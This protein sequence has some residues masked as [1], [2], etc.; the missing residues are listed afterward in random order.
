MM[1]FVIRLMT[2]TT[3]RCADAAW[4]KAELIVRTGFEELVLALASGISAF[5]IPL[6]AIRY[7]MNVNL[8]RFTVKV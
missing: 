7:P 1:L 2:F 8:M 4:A 6:S 5:F 3:L